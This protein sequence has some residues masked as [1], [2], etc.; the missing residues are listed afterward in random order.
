MK[1]TIRGKD[2]PIVDVELKA[3]ESLYT[4]SGGM[5]WKS[6]NV[7]MDSSV[8]G[9]VGGA[10]GRMFTGE[11]LF[12]V[13][14]ACTEGTGTVS[15][16]CEMP[17][18]ILDLDI[19]PDNPII[20]QR[21]AFMAAE[22]TVELTVEFTKRL[23]AGFFGGEGFI[24]QK[25]TGSGKAFLEFSGELTEYKL[26]EGQSLEIDPGYVGAFEHTVTYDIRRVEG[27]KN[28][29]FSGEGLFLA[30]L[31]GPGT[32][33]LQSMPLQNLAAKLHRYMPRK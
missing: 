9:G 21:D 20:C 12:L 33:W 28:M 7:S 13:T 19:T 8:R 10:L 6:P 17:G 11:S 26:K 14:Y 24:L 22:P 25:L 3:G 16:C 5:A 15:F 2:M 18:N 32:V 23:G 30:V 27:I 4:E 29:L 1:Y 31:E